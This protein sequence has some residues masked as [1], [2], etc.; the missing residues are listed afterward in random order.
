MRR[1]AR[2]IAANTGETVG[3]GSEG[4]EKRSFEIARGEAEETG[5]SP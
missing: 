2:A 5:I 3:R 1:S 4:D